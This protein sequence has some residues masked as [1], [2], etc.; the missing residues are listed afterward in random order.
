MQ[1]IAVTGVDDQSETAAISRQLAEAFIKQKGKRVLWAVW[2]GNK[3]SGRSLSELENLPQQITSAQLDGFL[4]PEGF[5][6]CFVRLH[7]TQASLE[8][9]SRF[10]SY[11]DLCLF[12][13]GNSDWGEVEKQVLER[14]NPVV[15]VMSPKESALLS[16]R[17]RELELSHLQVLSH[18]VWVVGHK[19]GNGGKIALEMEEKT[20]IPKIYSVSPELL[21]A[22]N[23]KEA[24]PQGCDAVPLETLL[25]E[26]RA[27]L[28]SDASKETI[29]EEIR[30]FLE[31][32]GLRNETRLQELTD[33]LFGLGPL[34]SLISDP[35]VTEIMVNGTN[36]I[37]V[38]KK[39]LL[40]KTDLHFVN[41][42]ELRNIIDRI[43]MPLGR[44]IDESQPMVDARLSDGSRVNAVIPPLALDGPML[45]IRRFSKF[46]LGP[47]DLV[48]SGSITEEQI[49][50]LQNAVLQKKNILISG[51][52]GTGKT[53]FLNILSS[54]IPAEERVVTIEDAAELRLAK[55]HVVR[56]E[57]RPANIEGEGAVTI[58]DLVRNALRMRPDRIVVGECRGA[59]A[60]DMLQ[61][62]NTGH[63]GSMTTI[64]ANSAEDAFG[65]LETLVCFAGLNLPSATIQKQISSAIDVVVQ[66]ARTGG[67]QRKV[68]EVLHV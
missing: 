58:R 7:K 26:L 2:D 55:P 3:I 67:G 51:G 29:K 50:D 25:E 68:V 20:G 21:E 19:R 44:R 53:T 30:L 13:L 18:P 56:L 37:F 14:A 31:R 36:P 1:M 33:L 47:S 52:T 24:V 27:Q 43:L 23:Q 41:E 66:L 11:F 17:K 40:A 42:R 16:I 60:L 49:A 9:L 46:M 35:A 34:E 63:N 5:P 32:K 62:M 38:E 59:E 45:T 15:V 12:D 22:L 39:G 10:S 48:Q 61:A 8:V 28:K 6:F 57:A 65:R 64:H 54:F 4:K